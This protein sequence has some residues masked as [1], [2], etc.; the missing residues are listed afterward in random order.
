MHLLWR[1]YAR[2]GSAPP[3]FYWLIGAGFTALAIFALVREDWLVAAIA[4]VIIAVTAA[5]S[6]MLRRMIDAGTPPGRM[7]DE[8][9]R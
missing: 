3:W 9:E 4:G 6:V 1:R 5:G 2:S 8:H 7:E